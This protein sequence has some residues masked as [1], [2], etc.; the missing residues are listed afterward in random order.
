VSPLSGFS[1]DSL[2]GFGFLQFGSDIP[3]CISLVICPAWY[4]LNF[5]DLWGLVTVPLLIQLLLTFLNNESVSC[6]VTSNAFVTLMDYS[7]PGS[8]VLGILLQARILEWVAISFSRGSSQSRDR[9][10]VS[11]IAADSL[12][13][14]PP[15]GS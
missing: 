11:C 8:L 14:E 13:S 2:F 10:R 7:L 5:L 3:R 15:G 6:S 12:P 9:T 1:Q 4:S